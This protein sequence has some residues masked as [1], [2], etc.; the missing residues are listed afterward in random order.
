MGCRRERI[1][2][3]PELKH[4]SLPA[5]SAGWAILHTTFEINSRSIRQELEK[6]YLEIA[7][8]VLPTLVGILAGV[9]SV[10]TL[11]AR[12]AAS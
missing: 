7:I 5:M 2:H 6:M 8:V 9:F 3:I 11:G 10:A 4:G 1:P 12:L